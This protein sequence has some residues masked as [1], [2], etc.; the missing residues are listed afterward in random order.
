LKYAAPAL[1]R[2][3]SRAVPSAAHGRVSALSSTTNTGGEDVDDIVIQPYWPKPTATTHV[4]SDMTKHRV[5][6]G[7]M[8]EPMMLEERTGSRS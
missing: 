4:T 1:E 3:A 5:G 7:R 6:S 2:A 8:S